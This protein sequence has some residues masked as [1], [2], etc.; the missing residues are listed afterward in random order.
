M[1]FDLTLLLN[2]LTRLQTR[3]LHFSLFPLF[4]VR[5]F[6]TSHADRAR[7]VS[8]FL[9]SELLCS[10]ADCSRSS[11]VVL[12][13]LYRDL[14]L[15][16]VLSYP[17]QYPSPNHTYTRVTVTSI[18]YRTYPS[19]FEHQKTNFSFCQSNPPV[20]RGENR[21]AHAAARRNPRNDLELES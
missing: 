8:S 18:M 7:N 5:F 9:I 2:A 3:F 17:V 1:F 21:E 15:F 12:H 16:N 10:I 19:D 6:S 20:W 11:I 14:E 4:V 13:M